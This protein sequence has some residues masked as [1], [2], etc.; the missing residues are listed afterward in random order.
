MLGVSADKRAG[1]GNDLLRSGGKRTDCVSLSGVG[2]LLFV[3]LIYN[4]IVEEATHFLVDEFG[5]LEPPQ[6]ASQLPQ[7][8]PAI[9]PLA[10]HLALGEFRS[11]KVNPGLT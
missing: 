3:G 5:R 8:L 4:E 10:L 6:L 11:L 1:E 7:R 9:L 2:G